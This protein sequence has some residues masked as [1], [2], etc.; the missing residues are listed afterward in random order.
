MFV[1][2]YLYIKGKV[3]KTGIKN[4]D[5]I[6]IIHISLLSSLKLLSWGKIIQSFEIPS[7]WGFK[8]KAD[9]KSFC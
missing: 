7:Y 1:Y 8:L 3:H 2:I 4:V 9:L 5:Y 6:D